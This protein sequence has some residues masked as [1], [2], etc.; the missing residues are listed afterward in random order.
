M[1]VAMLL[2]LGQVPS[3]G[4]VVTI[5]LF[6]MKTLELLIQSLQK[7]LAISRWSCFSHGV[8]LKEFLNE[9]VYKEC[10]SIFFTNILLFISQECMGQLTWHKWHIRRIVPPYSIFEGSTLDNRAC[11]PVA[12]VW[13]LRYYDATLSLRYMLH[14]LTR[15]ATDQQSKSI[16]LQM[17]HSDLTQR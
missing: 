9:F 7:L 16:N 5:S 6:P 13:G 8:I 4:E 14:I 3:A 17:H 10:S 15:S 2:E 12:K 11:S 1:L